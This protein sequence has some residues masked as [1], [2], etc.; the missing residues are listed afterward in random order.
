MFLL[1][2]YMFLLVY[3]HKN[4]DHTLHSTR[5]LCTLRLSVYVLKMD[6]KM[7]ANWEND[8]NGMDACMHAWGKLSVYVCLLYAPYK[9]TV[10]VLHFNL[11]IDMKLILENMIKISTKVAAGSTKSCA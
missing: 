11:I 3:A 5:I 6:K 2:I 7:K 4:P 10:Y 8:Y 1:L 9:N